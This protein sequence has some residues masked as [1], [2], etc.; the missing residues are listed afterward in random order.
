VTSRDFCYWLQGYLE[1]RDVHDPQGLSE[2]QLSTITKHL[3]LVFEHEI[4]PSMGG[5]LQ[6]ATLDAIH[7]PPGGGGGLIKPPT[8][9][10]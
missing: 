6:Q 8:I 1:L 4:D 9:R 10:C 7:N 3:A 2:A 5:P